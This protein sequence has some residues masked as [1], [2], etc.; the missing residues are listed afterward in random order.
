AQDFDNLPPCGFVQC[1]LPDENWAGHGGPSECAVPR[2]QPD[3]RASPW[4]PPADANRAPSGLKTTLRTKPTW[5]LSV[6]SPRPVAASQIFTLPSLSAVATL[7]PSGL[8]ATL[9]TA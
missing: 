6:R 2:C 4:S 1:L 9:Q 5:P 8:N 3:P 7:R